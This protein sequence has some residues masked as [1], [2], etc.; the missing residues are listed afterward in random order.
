MCSKKYKKVCK[1]CCPI[2]VFGTQ[3]IGRSHV[4]KLY[5][6]LTKYYYF[7]LLQLQKQT[8]KQTRSEIES[9]K[10]S[11]DI[12]TSNRTNHRFS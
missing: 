7:G 12:D 5:F 4:W 2:T 10:T 9:E 1:R 8:K 11:H 6:F 3:F